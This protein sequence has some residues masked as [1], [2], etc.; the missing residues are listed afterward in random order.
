MHEQL[1]VEIKTPGT[2]S[3]ESVRKV[4]VCAGTACRANGAM[5]VYETF[6]LEIKKAGF[7]VV[8]SFKETLSKK[9][10]SNTYRT[11]KSGCQGFCQ[12]GPL[13]TVEPEGILYVRVKAD[14]VPE[15]VGRTLVKKELVDRAAQDKS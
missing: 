5:K 6:V 2:Q 3:P 14:D 11:S 10:L 13:V 8:E 15:I 4:I 12:M 9:D 1:S 7:E